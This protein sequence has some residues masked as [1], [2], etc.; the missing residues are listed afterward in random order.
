[1]V[2]KAGPQ[3]WIYEECQQLQQMAFRFKDKE[4]PIY[5][6]ESLVKNL[7]IYTLEEALEGP[8]I[9]SEFRKDLLEQVLD[10]LVPSKVW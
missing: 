10:F 8:Y 5:Y 4:T 3:E 1:M 2:R 7:Q 9:M 6:L